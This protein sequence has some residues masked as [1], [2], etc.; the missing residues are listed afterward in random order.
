MVPSVAAPSVVVQIGMPLAWRPCDYQ[1]HSCRALRY[2][3]IQQFRRINEGR[4]FAFSP[5][6]VVDEGLYRFVNKPSSA[7][8]ASEDGQSIG[9]GIGGQ[10]ASNLL[11]QF[12]PGECHP[13]R[14][15][16]DTAEQINGS[17]PAQILGAHIIP[18]RRVQVR[19]LDRGH[20]R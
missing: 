10:F 15:P 11:S 1:I 4:R 7:M 17:N 18:M 12:S 2:I 3:I 8:V 13:G 14:Q 20:R 16:A 19:F 6:A 9:I 5:Y